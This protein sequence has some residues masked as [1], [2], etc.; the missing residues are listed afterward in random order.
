LAEVP[1]VY[2][3]GRFLTQGVTGVQRSALEIVRAL[4]GELG[5]RSG[6]GATELQVTVLAPQ[7]A[8]EPPRLRNI[9]FRKVGKLRGHLWEQLELPVHARRGPLVSFAN[10][11]PLVLRNQCVTIHDASV[12]ALPETYVP[13]Y[14]LWYRWALPRLGR[15]ARRILT[16]SRFSRAELMRWAAIT[17][18]KI[19]VVP[20]AAN[21]MLESPADERIL[22]RHSLR[23]KTFVLA[24]GSQSPHKNLD[25]VLRALPL[26]RAIPFD[27]VIV[28]AANPQIFRDP[29]PSSAGRVR[30]LGYVSDAELRALY[31]AATCLVFPSRYEGFGLPPLEAMICGCPVIVSHAASLPEV[32]GDAALYCDPSEPAGFAARIGELLRAPELRTEL[33]RRGLVQAGRFSWAASARSVLQSIDSLLAI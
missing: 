23:G 7:A 32:C 15:R 2:L 8:R 25:V 22:E 20:L 27:L 6:G 24:V 12:F 28:G 18:D 33:R 11:G 31:Q 21:H 14:R 17:E 16:D 13:A 5:A 30:R 9:G 29:P 10:S 19:E 4:D 3:N 1:Q 26:V